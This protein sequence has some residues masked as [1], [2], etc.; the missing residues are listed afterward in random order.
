VAACALLVLRT[1]LPKRKKNASRKFRSRVLNLTHRS[2]AMSFV[3]TPQIRKPIPFDAANL[4]RLMDEANLDV[5]VATSKHNIQYLLGG[6]RFFFYETMD[7]IGISRYQNAVVYQKG[8]P[9]NAAYI[10]SRNEKFEFELG[11]FWTPALNFTTLSPT[12]AMARA[13]DHIKS[14]SGIR[15]VGIEADFLPASGASTLRSALGNIEIGDAFLPLERLRAVKTPQEIQHLTAASEK[16]VAA[17]QV[18]FAACQPG[19]TKAD[20]VEALRRAEV[21]RGLVF[22]YCLITAGTSLNRAPSNQT[23]SAGDILSIDS[24][25]NANGYI[26]D[27]CRMGY[28][29]AKPDS[30]LVDLL[31]W[32]ETVQQATRVIVKPGTHGGDIL[33]TGDAM[34]EKSPHKA[35]ADFLAHG[36]G[37]VSHE[38][39]RLRHMGKT[40][41]YPGYDAAR[42]LQAGMVL[43]LETTMRHPKRGFIKLEDTILVTETGHVSLGDG[44][45]GWNRA[46]NW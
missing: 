15:R 8:K 7:A 2:G 45:R 12:E 39:P 16:V 13:A 24:G 43:S 6:Y 4:D 40:T 31:A 1:T 29:G 37:L 33:V 30:E 18:A 23:L 11:K 28:M 32:I 9:E 38:A 46:G 25:A 14:L 17:M 10:G 35:C 20:I 22:D 26:G 27:L 21:D 41:T 19:R 34:V 3:Q 36:M 44:A 5:I 42:P